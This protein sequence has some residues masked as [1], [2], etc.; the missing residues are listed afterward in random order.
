MKEFLQ[1]IN[2]FF[3]NLFGDIGKWVMLGVFI[4]AVIL[5]IVL[6]AYAIVN[7]EKVIFYGL[8]VFLVITFCLYIYNKNKKKG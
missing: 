1:S 3:T 4:V 2:N 5:S 7:I 8:L 6:I